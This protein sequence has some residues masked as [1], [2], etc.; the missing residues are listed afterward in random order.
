M[1][2]GRHL[3]MEESSMKGV[4]MAGGAFLFTMVL[5]AWKIYFLLQFYRLARR[6]IN[7]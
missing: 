6:F 7:Q 5:V 1:G 4:F 3:K 2:R